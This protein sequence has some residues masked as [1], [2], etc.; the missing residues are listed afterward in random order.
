MGQVAYL[1]ETNELIEA[2]SVSDA[3]WADLIS[4]PK[5]AILMPRSGWPAVPKTSIRGVR[6]FAHHPGYG[7]L[8]PKPE[9]YAHTRLKI[10]VVK[11]ARRLGYHAELELPGS[12]PNRA[13]WVA[14]VMVTAA[15][16]RRTAFEIQLSSQHLNDFRSRTGRYQRSGVAC[17]W[18]IPRKPVHERLTK[19]L[20]YANRETFPEHGTSRVMTAIWF[21]LWSISWERMITQPIP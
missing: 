21:S 8:L 13:E 9:S 16:G 19:A 2:F 3:G 10:D 18:I 17:C 11:A 5:G 4:A 6:F 15:D 20:C 1:A 7:G 12:D 14:D